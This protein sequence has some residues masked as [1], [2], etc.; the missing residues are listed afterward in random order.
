MLFSSKIPQDFEM[1]Y[2][3]KEGLNQIACSERLA[4]RLELSLY[5]HILR[6]LVKTMQ[7]QYAIFFKDS[8]GF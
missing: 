3:N 4:A 1:I 5:A 6:H 8:S 2:G 7:A